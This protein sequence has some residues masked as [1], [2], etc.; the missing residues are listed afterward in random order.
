MVSSSEIL[1]CVNEKKSKNKIEFLFRFDITR[2]KS[3]YIFLCFLDSFGFG[4]YLVR[5]LSR[6]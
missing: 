6:A 4:T 5:R 1:R 2:E 3:L